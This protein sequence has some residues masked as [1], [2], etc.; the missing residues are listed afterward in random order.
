MV[1]YEIEAYEL[2]KCCY[3][4]EAENA[5]EALE[6]FKEGDADVIDHT[7]EYLEWAEYYGVDSRNFD[8]DVQ[9]ELES[10]GIKGHMAGIR[11]ISR[12]EE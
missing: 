12:S 7:S 6:K 5:A 9:A 2:W 3:R 10:M 4:T 1:I 8:D 11:D